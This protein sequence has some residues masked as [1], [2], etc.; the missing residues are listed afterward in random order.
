MCRQ[1]FQE[2]A[3]TNFIKKFGAFLSC[4]LDGQEDFDLRIE[5][6]IVNAHISSLFPLINMNYLFFELRKT[7]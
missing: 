5:I 7:H 1:L 4:G 3:K 6:L 2:R